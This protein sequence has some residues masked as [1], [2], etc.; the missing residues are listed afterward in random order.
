MTKTTTRVLTLNT[1]DRDFFRAEIQD[2]PSNPPLRPKP[3][4]RSRRLIRRAHDF[5]DSQVHAASPESGGEAAFQWALRIVDVLC[6]HMSVVSVSSTDE[7]N[8]AAVFE[9]LND[10]RIGLSTPDLLRNLLLSRA[11]SRRRLGSSPT[12][13]T[14]AL[15][16]SSCPQPAPDIASTIRQRH[17]PDHFGGTGVEQVRIGRRNR[18][19]KAARC[20]PSEAIREPDGSIAPL[21]VPGS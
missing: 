8:A 17:H 9:T 15:P 19:G 3:T 21:I 6:N 20:F 4:L 5:L 1:Y 13:G 18:L 14:N 2:E 10:R 12:P 16:C 7:D 11:R